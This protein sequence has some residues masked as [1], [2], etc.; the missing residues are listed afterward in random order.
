[1]WWAS[2]RGENYNEI[3]LETMNILFRI[4]ENI[5]CP[6]SVLDAHLKWKYTF[7]NLESAVLKF[8]W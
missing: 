5:N 4:Y 1:M 7:Y 6:F 8:S 2:K 3:F